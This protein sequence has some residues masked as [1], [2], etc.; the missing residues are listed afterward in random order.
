MSESEQPA[1]VTVDLCG[2][3]NEELEAGQTCGQLNCPNLA[4]LPVPCGAVNADHEPHP[5][6]IDP[7]NGGS[8]VTWQCP[9][10][11]QA[12]PE[13]C[14]C[15][16]L[17][18]EGQRVTVIITHPDA[19]A[20]EASRITMAE[21]VMGEPALDLAINQ[22]AFT[23]EIGRPGNDVHAAPAPAPVV[24]A[25]CG[26]YIHT[27]SDDRLYDTSGDPECWASENGPHRPRQEQVQR[28]IPHSM[29]GPE[30]DG[31]PREGWQS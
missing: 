15:P 23:A 13:T 11:R 31:C 5:W 10:G 24:C 25:G 7:A 14:D 18:A 22:E 8:G 6:S 26:D 4:R 16:K 27:G 2:C 30:H 12:L 20:C 17:E 28:C 3:T 9:G 21:V 1:A 29:T 19:E